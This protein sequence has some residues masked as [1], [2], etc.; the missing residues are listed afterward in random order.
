M[1]SRGLEKMKNANER[2]IIIVVV[3]LLGIMFSSR[4]AN[5]CSGLLQ[6]TTILPPP[7]PRQNCLRWFTWEVQLNLSQTM[8][9]YRKLLSYASR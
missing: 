4:V 9:Q 2:K 3:L 6:T 7:S 8:L 1:K 5:M